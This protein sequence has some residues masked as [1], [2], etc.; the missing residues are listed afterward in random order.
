METKILTFFAVVYLGLWLL[1]RSRNSVLSRAA[2]SWL[3][4]F[5]AAGER[6]S[7]FQFRWA[8][9]SFWWLCQF[10]I[11]LCVLAYVP[12]FWPETKNE[13]WLLVSFFALGLGVGMATLAFV[14]FLF[15][16]L[17]ARWLGPNPEFQKCI[18]G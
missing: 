2:F 9:Y 14:A 16:S 15:K 5:P 8:I 17:K 12:T 13:D 18:N 4:P 3:G 7:S 10:V 1:K 11:V 6:W